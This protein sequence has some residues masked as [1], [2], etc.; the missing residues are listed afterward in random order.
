MIL[1]KSA[2]FK[3][4]NISLRCYELLKKDTDTGPLTFTEPQNE[5]AVFSLMI[6]MLNDRIY[7]VIQQR[8]VFENHIRYEDLI[9][10]NLNWIAADEDCQ[11]YQRMLE[12]ICHMYLNSD[13]QT[14]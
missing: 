12:E 11:R 7:P 13:A 3:E 1:T 8:P 2:I 5:Y 4:L 14:M 6:H 10:W 9:I